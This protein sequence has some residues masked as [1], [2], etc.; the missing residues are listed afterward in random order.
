MDAILRHGGPRLCLFRARS[1]IRNGELSAVSGAAWNTRVV[2]SSASY[3]RSS[4]KTLRNVANVA[5]IEIGSL[6]TGTGVGREI[7]VR[8]RNI[9]AQTLT[10]SAPLYDAEGTQTFTFTRFRYLLEFDGFDKLSNVQF[11]NVTFA[12][13]GVSS[14]ILMAR[15]GFAFQLRDCHMT[16]PADRGL[17]SIG[18]G[19]QDLLIDRCQFMSNEASAPAQTRRTLVFNANA[20]DVK[21]RDNR[22]VRFRHFCV[23]GGDGTILTGNHWFH[24]DNEPDGVRLGGLVLTKTN[25]KTMIPGNYIDNN[26]IEW[27]NEHEADPAMGNQYSFGG[28]TITGNT[29]TN[30]DVADWFRWI[31]VKPYGPGHFIHGL[32]VTGNVFRSLNGSIGRVETVNTAIADLDRSMMR[33]V[34]FANNVFHGV[35]VET[36]NPLSVGH[37]QSSAQSTWTVDTGGQLPFDGWARKVESI[38]P[39]NQIKQA[40]GTKSYAFPGVQTQQGGGKD[41]IQVIWP[42]AVQGKV[43]CAIRMD[44]PN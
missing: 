40:N 31:V 24:G 42:T 36:V 13:N 2:S 8:D 5:N 39:E 43:R 6:V 20:N 18:R 44:N 37:T 16:K 30:N 17:T 28:L 3:A 4:A 14:G 11:D 32:T 10:L 25:P 41:Q 21:I 12:C 15:D 35:D 33:N 22:I 27:T 1:T 38:A 29:F 7:Y 23:L 34:V 26:A 9:G 19:C